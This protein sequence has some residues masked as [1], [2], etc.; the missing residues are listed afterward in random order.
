MINPKNRLTVVHFNAGSFG[1]DS[2]ASTLETDDYIYVRYDKPVNAAYINLLASN[3]NSSNLTLEYYNGSGFTDV[4][5]FDDD[6]NGLSRSAFIQWDRDLEEDQ[7]S[8][9]DASMPTK[10]YY[11][12]S[13]DSDTTS[14]TIQG[15]NIVF[16]DDEDLRKEFYCIDDS[17]ILPSGASSHI[18]THEAVKDEIV[19][20]FRNRGFNKQREDSL[21]GRSDLLAWDLLQIDEVREAAKFLALH[22]IFFNMSDAPDDVWHQKALYYRSQYEDQIKI[23]NLSLDEDNDGETDDNER[24]TKIKHDRVTR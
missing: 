23:A 6:T 21:G 24:S 2:F 15:I 3:T 7:A 9:P 1:R 18:L 11:R 19:Q 10:N 16:A 20:Y 5:S 22:K 13:T 8:Q 12:I 14:L 4:S 17:S